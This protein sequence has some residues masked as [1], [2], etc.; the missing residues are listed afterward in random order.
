SELTRVPL[1]TY[2]VP[3]AIGADARSRRLLGNRALLPSSNPGGYLAT[4]PLLLT[5]LSALADILPDSQD[6]SDAPISAVRVRVADVRG[7]DE[8]SRER[9]RKVAEDIARATGLDVD[10]TVGSSPAPQTVVL[11]AGGYGRPELRLEEAW[12]KKGVAVVIATAIDRKSMV[13]F[14]LILVVCALFLGNAT[15]A[16]VR[17]RRRELAVL[18]CLGWPARHLGRAILGEVAAIGLAAGLLGA[19][20]S[21]PV[22]GAVGIEVSPYRALLA[23]PAAVAL[24]VLAGVMPALRASRAHPA[25]A[26]RPA[27]LP[28]RRARRRRTVLGLAVA[29]VARVPGRTLLGAACLGVGVCGLT[30]VAAVTWAFHGAVVGSLL[31]DA[32]SLRVRGVDVAAVAVTMAL[33]ALAVA[34]VLYLNLRERA[35]EFA[36]LSATGWSRSALARLIGYEGLAVGLLGALLGAAA[37]FA[38]AAW[39][40]GQVTPRLVVTGIAAAATG[41]LLTVGTALVPA[42]L[43]HRQPLTTLLAEEQA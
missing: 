26:V 30:L 18:A 31:G 39:F 23:V 29:N 34:D 10:V 20:L 8:V 40:A 11:P 3:Q 32:V 43:V 6:P 17:D 27:V 19:G 28:A 25:A 24:A 37:G 15:L 41:V 9:V 12:S 2:Q 33:G 38:G 4:P 35:N 13:L 14:A 5:T 36:A 21:V 1:E 16:A 7:L 22:G 42:W